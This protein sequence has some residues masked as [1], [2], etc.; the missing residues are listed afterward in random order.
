MKTKHFSAPSNNAARVVIRVKHSS[1]S[2]NPDMKSGASACSN[3]STFSWVEGGGFET[4]VEFPKTD[5]LLRDDCDI[6]FSFS[7]EDVGG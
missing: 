2:S 1:V 4:F 6:T 5:N 7:I 3:F